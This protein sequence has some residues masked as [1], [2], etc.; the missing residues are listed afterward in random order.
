MPFISFFAANPIVVAMFNSV[1]ANCRMIS[2]NSALRVRSA[3]ASPSRRDK[4]LRNSRFSRKTSR[5]DSNRSNIERSS[6][7]VTGFAGAA[8]VVVLGGSVAVVSFHIDPL[9]YRVRFSLRCL[10]PILS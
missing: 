10:R 6:S 8:G 4:T 2:S 7:S 1:G 5:V 9:Q 3:W